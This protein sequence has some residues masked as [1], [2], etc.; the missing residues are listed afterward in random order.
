[1]LNFISTAISFLPVCKE[2]LIYFLFK[3]LKQV[4]CFFAV[5]VKI[6]ADS[7]ENP[8]QTAK[9]LSVANANCP[10]ITKDTPNEKVASYVYFNVY[11]GYEI[12]VDIKVLIQ[13]L[14]ICFNIELSTIHSNLN[15][16]KFTRHLIFSFLNVFI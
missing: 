3:F 8:F 6:N 1:M 15:P 10:L 12:Q 11:Y 5:V 2:I 14:V 4:I 16:R 9:Q 13:I 7:C